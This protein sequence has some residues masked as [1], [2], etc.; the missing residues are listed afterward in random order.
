[1]KSTNNQKQMRLGAVHMIVTDMERMLSFYQTYLGLQVHWKKAGQAGVGTGKEDLVV[2]HEDPAAPHFAQTTNIYHFAIFMADRIT[3]AK[4][5]A[6]LM[7]KRWPNYP[8]DHLI[9]ETTYLEDPEGNTI[10][11]TLETPERGTIEYGEDGMPE[12]RDAEGNLRS[13]RDPVDVQ[14]LF[15]TLKVGEDLETLLPLS[16]RIHHVHL[17]VNDMEKTREFYR[18]II[19]FNEMSFVPQIG[20]AD[21]GPLGYVV[22]MLAYNIWRGEGAAPLPKGA[23][24]LKYFTVVLPSEAD[25]KKALERA[26]KAGIKTKELDG[27]HLLYDPSQL[28]VLI[29]A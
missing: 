23:A 1:M 25:L 13:G 12:F 17:Y 19:G 28:G 8:T 10:E 16:T 14:A 3:F 9:S 20:M 6:R 22:H 18:D 26:E 2:L 21:M 11:L 15:K 24:G 7:A 29:K 4:A 27:G 5:V